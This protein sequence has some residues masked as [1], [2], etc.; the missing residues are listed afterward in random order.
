MKYLRY[1]YFACMCMLSYSSI[2]QTPPSEYSVFDRNTLYSPCK[3][4]DA[5]KAPLK[6]PQSPQKYAPQILGELAQAMYGE[7]PI[8]WFGVSGKPFYYKGQYSTK[9]TSHTTYISWASHSDSS[10]W[11]FSI[12]ELQR[13]SP[14]KS[15]FAIISCYSL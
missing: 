8:E 5:E 3:A 4:L 1:C 2:A 14:K 12:T 7:M 11:Y 6:A 15:P 9:K 13:S 10:E